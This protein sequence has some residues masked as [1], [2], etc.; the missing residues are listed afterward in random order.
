[1]NLPAAGSGGNDD[2]HFTDSL[3]RQRFS[4]K[5]EAT[6]T[7]HAPSRSICRHSPAHNIK[8]DMASALRE[9][10][11]GIASPLA[12]IRRASERPPRPNTRALSA[13]SSSCR[14][15]IAAA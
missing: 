9:F 1:M 15:F 7:N 6:A 5:E 8:S 3:V 4:D 13:S 12:S 2:L 10:F 14:C 11:A